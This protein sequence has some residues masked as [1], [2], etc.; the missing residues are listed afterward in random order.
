MPIT[1]MIWRRSLPVMPKTSRYSALLSGSRRW[2]DGERKIAASGALDLDH[3][4]TVVGQMPRGERRGDR[5]LQGDDDNAVQWSFHIDL[6]LLGSP[7]WP[8]IAASHQARCNLPFFREPSQRGM[9]RV[10]A[11]Q[12]PLSAARLALAL[13][14]PGLM[15]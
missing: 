11:P 2:R 8:R 4:R 6:R 10:C 13:Q 1:P 12:R 7:A 3:A 9:G 14:N 15:F 5:M